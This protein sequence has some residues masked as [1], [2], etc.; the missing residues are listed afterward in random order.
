MFPNRVALILGI[1]FHPS[2]VNSF[3]HLG[4]SD[5]LITMKTLQFRNIL[6]KCWIL[7]DTSFVRA[8]T[9]QHE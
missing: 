3:L 1:S 5:W 2:L 4:Q 8:P 6:D 9:T 7:E